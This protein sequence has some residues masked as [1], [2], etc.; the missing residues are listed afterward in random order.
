MHENEEYEK[1]K[2]V[3]N[4]SRAIVVRFG[5]KDKD[6]NGHADQ[7][8]SMIPPAPQLYWVQLESK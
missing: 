8:V 1:D 7:Q 3:T 6:S 2:I 4:R 5:S